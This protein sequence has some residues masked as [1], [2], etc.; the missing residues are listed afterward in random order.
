[1]WSLGQ[2]D[3]VI[4]HG[5]ISNGQ[6]SRR[7]VRTE[8]CDQ[9]VLFSLRLL[10]RGK[11]ATESR[12]VVVQSIVAVIDGRD[13]DGNHFPLDATERATFVH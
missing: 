4:Q 1:M 8:G 13:R 9:L 2:L 10:G 7:V 3:G 11:E 6:G 12:S 5:P